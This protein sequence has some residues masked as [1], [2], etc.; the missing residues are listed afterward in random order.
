MVAQ[1]SLIKA[2]ASV[3]ALAGAI[4]KMRAKFSETGKE[5]AKQGY[6][7][8]ANVKKENK[9]I[10]AKKIDP[11]NTNE[12]NIIHTT[13][14]VV[15]EKPEKQKF[16]LSEE[17]ATYPIKAEET[18]TNIPIDEDVQGLIKV[19]QKNAL[20]AAAG[21][22]GQESYQE[23]KAKLTGRFATEH[24]IED[25][26]RSINLDPNIDDKMIKKAGLSKTEILKMW[27]ATENS[28]DN[29]L[30]H[31]FEKN[32]ADQYGIATYEEDP[33]MRENFGPL[34]SEYIKAKADGRTLEEK[35][36]DYLA[37]QGDFWDDKE[38]ETYRVWQEE[39]ELTEEEKQ[40]QGIV[41]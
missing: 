10:I 6:E 4:S 9:E 36:R 39:R 3:I 16:I 40:A 23:I 30:F 38:D 25:V 37:Q 5:K 14:P 22:R 21:K 26:W 41:F 31:L 35:E 15:G 29:A 12:S 17:G 13:A 1:K 34:L 7:K 28:S 19:K 20:R 8:N 2:G 11:E 32:N 18:K 33:E 24:N 27:E